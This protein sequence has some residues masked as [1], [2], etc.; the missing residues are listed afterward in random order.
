[1]KSHLLPAALLLTLSAGLS[2]AETSEPDV[3]KPR[4]PVSAVP[5]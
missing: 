3:T 1:M 2:A 4:K 5:S